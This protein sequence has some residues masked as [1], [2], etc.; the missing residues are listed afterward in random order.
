MLLWSHSFVGVIL[1]SANFRQLNFSDKQNLHIIWHYDFL[2]CG[3]SFVIDGFSG[4]RGIAVKNRI[5]LE[6]S[7]DISSVWVHRLF[8]GL[9]DVN[10][11]LSNRFVPWYKPWVYRISCLRSILISK[12]CQKFSTI[13]LWRLSL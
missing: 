7:F 4:L 10:I 5:F 11:S 12:N 6:R 9:E 13:Y 8:S 3:T 2:S 1:V